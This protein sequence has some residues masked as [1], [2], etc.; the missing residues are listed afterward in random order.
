MSRTSFDQI[1]EGIDRHLSYLHKEQWIHRYAEL[2]DAV[3]TTTGEAQDRA[4]QALRD[5]YQTE[6]HPQTSRAA[7]IEQARLSYDASETG[8]DSP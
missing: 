8:S 3:R 7:L 5:H 2:M 4:K 1:V 6:Y